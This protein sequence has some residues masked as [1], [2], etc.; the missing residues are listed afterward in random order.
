[1]HRY[2]DTEQLKKKQFFSKCIGLDD[3]IAH[4]PP[5]RMLLH[6]FISHP[7]AEN[8]SVL[9]IMHVCVC[10]G[11]C[12]KESSAVLQRGITALRKRILT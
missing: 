12:L 6:H 4:Q 1:M 11:V 10:V 7:G 5:Q 9:F 3:A 2:H 8:I